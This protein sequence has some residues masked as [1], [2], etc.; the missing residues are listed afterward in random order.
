M[1]DQVLEMVPTP[2]QVHV[3]NSSQNVSEAIKDKNM[4]HKDLTTTLN[5]P[6]I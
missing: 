3:R 6:E 5:S 2:K 4:E 1:D